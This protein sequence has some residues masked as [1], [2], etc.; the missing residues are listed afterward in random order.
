M[1]GLQ[2]HATLS[3]LVFAQE[4]A[5]VGLGVDDDDGGIVRGAVVGADGEIASEGV[6]G[7]DGRDRF[8]GEGIFAP[9]GLI[10]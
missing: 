10:T 5:F 2:V 9:S 1:K 6:L 8:Q 4:D 3:G 7:G